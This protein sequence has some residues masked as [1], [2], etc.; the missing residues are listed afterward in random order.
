MYDAV[1]RFIFFSFFVGV[2]I[3]AVVMLSF[4]LFH[5]H[6]SIL[7]RVS[8]PIGCRCRWHFHIS[9]R[10]RFSFSFILSFFFPSVVIIWINLH[11]FYQYI[12]YNVCSIINERWT[13]LALV[14][15]WPLS[16]I[17]FC[18]LFEIIFISFFET[19]NWKLWVFDFVS[20]VCAVFVTCVISILNSCFNQW[21]VEMFKQMI[22]ID[23]RIHSNN[24]NDNDNSNNLVLHIKRFIWSTTFVYYLIE[25]NYN[26]RI[27]SK[28]QNHTEKKTL[29]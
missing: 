17:G 20:F 7:F 16:S 8:F 28:K 22:G 5:C 12:Y 24:S 4:I 26:K 1:F 2:I 25:E 14:F 18:A 23:L 15:F 29:K 13:H 27:N 9:H 6:V 21:I 19:P 10:Y 3:V 11:A